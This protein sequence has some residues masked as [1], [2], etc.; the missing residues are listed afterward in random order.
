MS[1]KAVEIRTGDCVKEMRTILSDSVPLICADPPYNIGK[2]YENYDDNKPHD[3]FM[4][5]TH[6]WIAQAYRTLHPQGALFVFAPDEWVSEL[7]VHCRFTL[8]LHR[9]SWIVW[10]YTFGVACQGRFSR[11]HTHV[12]WFTKH[13]TKFT[14]NRDAIAVP[15]NRQLVYNDKRANPKG[16]LP[17]DVW[18][19][20]Q[21]AMADCFGPDEDTWLVSRVCGT[22]KERQKHSSNQI[23]LPIMER[24]ILA[25]S[26]PGDLVL[27]PFLGTGT[28]GVAA[29]HHGRRFTGFDISETC[30]QASLK[31][32]AQEG[33]ACG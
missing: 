7:D 10:H 16:K 31:R 32:I 12:L 25:C 28:T 5:W 2:E 8:G 26:N 33:A 6:R 14:F 27:D 22:F 17:D 3:E 9:Q 24:I 21:K 18:M 4:A 11:S 29:V 19:L 23:P 15:S 13:S 1:Q 20:T 30:V